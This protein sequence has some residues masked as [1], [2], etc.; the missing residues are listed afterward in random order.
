VFNNKHPP[1]VPAG[2][3]VWP[4][5]HVKWKLFLLRRN[6]IFTSKIQPR[7]TGGRRRPPSPNMHFSLCLAGWW[8]AA[9]GLPT[10]IS[11]ARLSF[12][13]HLNRCSADCISPSVRE[14]PTL[15]PQHTALETSYLYGLCQ[16]IAAHVAGMCGFRQQPRYV[17]DAAPNR[18]CAC[19]MWSLITHTIHLQARAAFS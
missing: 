8:A 7:V 10:P 17:R 19:L 2:A 16:R 4:L 11:R 14:S 9:F 12:D 3:I 18:Q 5:W 1:P 6:H 15:T 13:S